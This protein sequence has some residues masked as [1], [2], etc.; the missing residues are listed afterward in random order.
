M[1]LPISILTLFL[2]T[3]PSITATPII[4]DEMANPCKN[5]MPSCDN[6]GDNYC[7]AM[8]GGIVVE[9]KRQAN[10]QCWEY[11]TICGDKGPCE[12]LISL[13]VIVVVVVSGV[14]MRG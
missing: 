12:C 14:R 2:T 11:A 13:I 9:C 5:N 8:Y 10:V 3:L 7:L 6:I 4:T 1:K